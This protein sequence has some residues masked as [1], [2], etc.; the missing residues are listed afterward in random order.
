[1]LAWITGPKKSV[2]LKKDRLLTNAVMKRSAGLFT[3]LTQPM[4]GAEVGVK[5]YS[6][7]EKLEYQTQVVF[8]DQ[9]MAMLCSFKDSGGQHPDTRG[10]R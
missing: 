4:S 1:M 2:S 3:L 5:T 7:T 8:G 10:R 6:I 9:E